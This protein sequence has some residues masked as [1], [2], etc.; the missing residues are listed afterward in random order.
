MGDWGF[1]IKRSF[2]RKVNKRIWKFEMRE[3]KEGY[4][5]YSGYKGYGGYGGYGGYEF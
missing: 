1:N 3:F 5:S 4:K 2:L